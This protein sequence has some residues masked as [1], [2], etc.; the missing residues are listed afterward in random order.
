[1]ARATVIEL[2]QG[3]TAPA[4]VSWLRRLWVGLLKIVLR[5]SLLTVVLSGVAVPFS[6]GIPYAANRQA[7]YAQMVDLE[8]KRDAR[9]GG[10]GAPIGKPARFMLNDERALLPGY[11]KDGARYVDH[12]YLM[13]TGQAPLQVKTV[14]AWCRET[15][16]WAAV[17]GVIA[18]I[19]FLTA[20]G[21]LDR[22]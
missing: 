12:R 17:A 3:T 20:R 15:Q 22:E 8:A 7:V 1:M 2:G 10:L 13:A 9:I 14:E 19:V 6:I 4:R 21:Y 16:I 11:T 5:L 18:L